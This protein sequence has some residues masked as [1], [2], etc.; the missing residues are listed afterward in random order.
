MKDQMLKRRV[1]GYTLFGT[2]V[3]PSKIDKYGLFATKSIPKGT[4]VAAWGGRILTAKEIKKLESKFTT[5]YALEIYPGFYIAETSAQDLDAADF[6]NHSCEPNCK[7]VNRLIMIAKRKIKAGEELT[8][9][10][11]EGSQKIGKKTKCH[12]Q[13]LHC[14][15]IV[16]F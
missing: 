12:C 4:V 3:Q 1:H 8:A 13:S 9:D 14:R 2:E 10:F 6:I 5:N 15:K 11:D 7:I 16:Y